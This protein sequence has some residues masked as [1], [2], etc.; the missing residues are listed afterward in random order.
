MTNITALIN[1]LGIL[2][3]LPLCLNFN[4]QK[5]VT[6]FALYK[7]QCLQ[8]V[9]Q[10]T[11]TL[12]NYTFYLGE[13]LY[14]SFMLP[15]LSPLPVY[16]SLSLVV[17]LVLVLLYSLESLHLPGLSS[18]I[19]LLSNHFVSICFRSVSSEE[20]SQKW[21]VDLQHNMSNP[22]YPTNTSRIPP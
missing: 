11:T 16:T 5:I 15:S 3:N 12:G 8:Y 7:L 10:I 2:Q 19:P 9:T 20:Y 17:A 6:N 21:R 1:S 4:F 13:K 14:V 18:T 22:F